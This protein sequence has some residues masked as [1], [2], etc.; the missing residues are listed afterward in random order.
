MKKIC[1]L[2]FLLLVFACKKDKEETLPLSAEKDILSFVFTVSNTYYEGTISGTTITAQLP[3]DTDVTTLTPTISIS[4]GATVTPNSEVAQDFSKEVSYTVTAENK[5]TKTYK[6]LVTLQQKPEPQQPPFSKIFVENNTIDKKGGATLSISI[7]ASIVVEKEKIKVELVNQNEETTVYEL[8]VKKFARNGDLETQLPSSY[9]NGLYFLRVTIGEQTQ[10]SYLFYLNNSIPTFYFVSNLATEDANGDEFNRTLVVPNE[11]FP[12]EIFVNKKD[13][14]NYKFYLRKNGQ[15]YEIQH[16][17]LGWYTTVLFKMPEKAKFSPVGGKDFQFV[18]KH[19]GEEY[20]FPFLNQSKES[21]E[22]V[23]AQ[24]PV[25]NSV[26]KT[27]LMKGE[28]LVVKGQHFFYNMNYQKDWQTVL[29]LKERYTPDVT[30]LNVED[31]NDKVATFIIP[32]S[33]NVFEDYPYE[34]TITNDIGQES[35]PF[36]Q[37]INIE[38]RVPTSTPLSV[39]KAVVVK[40]DVPLYK[41]VD[42]TFNRMIRDA[43]IKAFVFPKLTNSIILY[44]YRSKIATSITLS[45]DQYNYLVNE[46]PKGY[47]IIRENG[48]EYQAEFSLVKGN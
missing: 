48:K 39:I 12:A 26:S 5:S 7:N 40:K 33:D 6:V 30:I 32:D 25:I 28:K 1:A 34:I 17:L 2:C 42:I 14:P 27:S 13:L 10:R 38:E 23:I 8:E 31:N 41:T 3:A 4:K 36:N 37:E 9:K 22:V 44:G 45:D 46:L 35:A 21:I 20:V 19:Q 43:S 29:K 16:T 15:D 47:V 11:L 24:P 18:M